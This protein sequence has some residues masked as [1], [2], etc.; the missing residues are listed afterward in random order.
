MRT[1]LLFVHLDEFRGPA[2]LD[3]AYDAKED[4][5]EGNLTGE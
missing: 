4:F 5:S 3:G 1:Y 2:G